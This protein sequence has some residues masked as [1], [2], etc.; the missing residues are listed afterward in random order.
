MFGWVQNIMDRSLYS[1]VDTVA[2]CF[3]FIV[4]VS[5]LGHMGVTFL[6][7]F[8]T[9]I[10][11]LTNGRK[12]DEWLMSKCN[13][14]EFAVHVSHMSLCE[15][16]LSRA[17]RNIRFAALS[18]A[19]EQLRYCGSYS[20]TELF[21]IL[22][23]KLKMSSLAFAFLVVFILI[24]IRYMYLYLN[25]WYMEHQRRQY[26][27]HICV[28]QEPTHALQNHQRNYALTWASQ[29]HSSLPDSQIYGGTHYSA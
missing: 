23:E 25:P 3:L 14:P 19:Y 22:L 15:N 7:L 21:L 8:S 5:W 10:H 2:K 1:M 12:Q 24:V 18:W 26:L 20:C 11:Y 28:P 6:D 17:D 4:V 16:V 27:T 13:E 29:R 9:R